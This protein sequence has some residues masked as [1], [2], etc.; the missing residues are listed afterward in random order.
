MNPTDQQLLHQ[1]QKQDAQAFECFFERHRTAS[2]RHLFGMVREAA[3]TD[4]LVQEVFLR[5]WTRAEQWNE[6]GAARAWLFRIATNLALNHLRGVRRRPQQPLE[7]PANP[8]LDEEEIGV[9][10]WMIDAAALQPEAA[11]MRSERMEQ[12]QELVHELP[13]DKRAVFGLVYE[14]DMDLRSAAAE[15]GIP[16]GTIKSR[17]YYAKKKLAQEWREWD[18]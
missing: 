13:E 5:V 17:L 3:A 18:E 15:L 1:I 6:Q 11:A 8:L 16:E 4:D 10:A 9:P 14:A 12:L 7:M 2:Q